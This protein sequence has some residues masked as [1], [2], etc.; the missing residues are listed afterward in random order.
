P[1]WIAPDPRGGRDG[2]AWTV[3]AGELSRAITSHAINTDNALGYWMRS[4]GQRGVFTIDER[5]NRA[6]L[7]DALD[8]ATLLSLNDAPYGF[9]AFDKLAVELFGAN[10]RS[11]LFARTRTI[12]GSALQRAPNLAKLGRVQRELM[13]FLAAGGDPAMRKALASPTYSLAKLPADTDELRRVAF[14]LDNAPADRAALLP[15][16]VTWSNAKVL[17]HLLDPVPTTWLQK[18]SAAEIKMY[19]GGLLSSSTSERAINQ[20]LATVATTI[21]AYQLPQLITRSCSATLPAKITQRMAA[22]KEPHARDS[23]NQAVKAATHCA[24]QRQ[25]LRSDLVTVGSGPLPR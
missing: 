3:G 16:P 18:R 2:I 13:F 7:F 12:A 22:T 19:V 9:S 4:V 17:A 11:I 5:S 10:D 24:A 6:T 8:L 1:A 20:V 14:A 21:D 23:L 25:R 15:Q